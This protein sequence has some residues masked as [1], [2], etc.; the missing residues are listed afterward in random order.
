MQAHRGCAGWRQHLE[1]QAWHQD[2]LFH[3]GAYVHG[4]RGALGG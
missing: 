4:E 1:I 3:R 2:G